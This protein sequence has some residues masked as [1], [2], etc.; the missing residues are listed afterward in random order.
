MSKKQSATPL[1]DRVI[2][3]P[4][5]VENKTLGG[6]IIPDNAK[7]KPVKGTVKFSAKDLTVKNGDTVLFGKH[8]GQEIIIGEEPFLIMRESD[9]LCIL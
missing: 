4:I 2:V 3:K 9:I 6:I 8:A 1:H 5:E 7:E